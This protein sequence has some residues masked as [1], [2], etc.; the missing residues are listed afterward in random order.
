MDAEVAGV[1]VGV[2]ECSFVFFESF[3]SPFRAKF[4]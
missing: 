2:N 4:V 3:F 1:G